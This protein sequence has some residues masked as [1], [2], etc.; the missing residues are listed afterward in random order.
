MKTSL[1][2]PVFNV[3][4]YLD[5]CLK[6][7]LRQSVDD[8]EVI[9]VDDGST[10]GSGDVCDAWAADK[11]FVTVIHQANG[12]LSAARNTGLD[13]ATG[14]IIAFLDSDDRL[15][16]GTLH[17]NL[18]Y[19]SDCPTLDLV[20]FPVREHEGS[21]D[22]HLLTFEPRWTPAHAAPSTLR[23]RGKGASPA[24]S[25]EAGR[26]VFADW[27]RHQGYT[28]CYVWNKLYRATLWKGRRFPVGQVFEDTAVMPDILLTCR[29]A[30]CSAR[31]CY[32]YM[33]RAGSISRTWRYADCRQLFLN[34]R[35][36]YEKASAMYGLKRALR[37]LRRSMLCRLIDMGR[38]TDCNQADHNRLLEGMSA[39]ERLLCRL[40]LLTLPPFNADDRTQR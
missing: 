37:P 17:D 12:G 14:D 11:P 13:H 20:E 19:F 34:Q 2:I 22:E 36:L 10:D 7:V 5:E 31:G 32:H 40:K 30:F 28:H 4:N 6:S 3:R 23:K 27:V 9:L 35:A 39:G 38:C 18:L 16:D 33:R 25:V 29:T 1:I 21:P 24:P 15:G 26:E 8:L